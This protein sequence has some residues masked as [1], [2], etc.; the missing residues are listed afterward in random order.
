MYLVIGLFIGVMIGGC[1]GAWWVGR[2]RPASVFTEDDEEADELRTKASKV[3]QARIEKRKMKIMDKA[4]AEGRITNDGVEDM[5]C[6]GDGT[7]GNYLRQ[8]V[9]EGLLLKV[10]TTG[11]GVYY[12]PVEES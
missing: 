8:L 2:N 5:F 6:I 3:V 1:I 4:R 10:G 11:R 9:D 7:A 12:I